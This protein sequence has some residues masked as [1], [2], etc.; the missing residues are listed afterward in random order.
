[1]LP[2][3]KHNINCTTFIGVACYLKKE[4]EGGCGREIIADYILSPK[5]NAGYFQF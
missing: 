3:N 2:C 1:M 5:F 4:L